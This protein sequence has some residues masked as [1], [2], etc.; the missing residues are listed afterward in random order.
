MKEP[1]ITEL[2]KTS[3]GESD[4]QNLRFDYLGNEFVY[5]DYNQNPDLVKSDQSGLKVFFTRDK[6]LI[7]EFVKIR[8]RAYIDEFEGGN[9]EDF[10]RSQDEF[11]RKGRVMLAVKNSE[12]IGGVRLMFSD[13]CDYLSNEHPGTQFEYNQVLKRYGQKTG[14]KIVEVSGV[15]V[16]KE[17]RDFSVVAAM[18][19][20]LLK[21]SIA[22][23]CSY[24]FGTSLI[25][26][27]RFYRMIFNK[28]GFYLEIVLS[29]PWERKELYG[30]AKMFPIYVKID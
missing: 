12:V 8:T 1:I 5:D 20:L 19:D 30:F 15:I 17:Y 25:V 11:D 3:E 18:F 14:L 10:T 6:D 23:S 24:I 29:Y 22:R 21:V 27:C 16:K 2:E 9:S 13:E 26:A 7:S 4:K 28:M